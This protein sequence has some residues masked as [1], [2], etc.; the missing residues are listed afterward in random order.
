MR[1]RRPRYGLRERIWL[2]VVAAMGVALL[3]LTAG[4]NLLVAGRLTDEANSVASARAAAELDAVRV[5][6]AGIQV[7]RA[8]GADP[9]DTPTWVFDARRAVE[10]PRAGAPEQ[11]AAQA[12]TRRGR[13]FVDAPSGNTRLYGLPILQ[14]GRRIGTVVGAVDLAPYQQIGT[15]ALLGS[16]ALAVLALV[17][18]G[19]ASRWI[20][21]RALRP[22]A[23]MT[24][25]ADDWS[26]HDLE[27]RFGLGE[28][29]DEFTTLAATLDRLLDRVAAS[30]RR[31]QNLT[32]DLSHELRTPLTQISTEAQFALRHG[33]ASPEQR[34]S[35]ERILRS[36]QY[37]ARILETLMAA[38]RAQAAPSPAVGD[39]AAAVR[40]AIEAVRP[41][42]AQHHIEVEL[43][44]GSV[45]TVT[46]G[47][48]A[49]IERVVAP[50]LE[51][52][53]RYARHRIAVEIADGSRELEIIVQDDGPGIPCDD[54][55]H[56]FEPGFRSAQGTTALLKGAGLGLALARRL[57][58][59]VGGDV[60]VDDSPAGA[61]VVVSLPRG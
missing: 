15:T 21:A 57:A 4:F 44:G 17:A 30:L 36:A 58:R 24:R 39:A 25:Q 49:L 31:E 50:L 13:G 48:D 47:D 37:T 11:A 27:R 14:G 42:A 51:N 32:A 43:L 52:A 46:G 12:L 55:Q 34:E 38:A 33:P 1:R 22:V 60:R 29:R 35:Y 5:S 7:I 54:A 40:A 45:A 56:V 53:C 59:G 28:P 18:I 8:S 6:T 61:R 41:L 10:R 19:V 2:T 3:G 20:L 23:E 16:S 9:F 26:E